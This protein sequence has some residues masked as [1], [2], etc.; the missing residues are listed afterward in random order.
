VVR[1]ARQAGWRSIPPPAPDA[2]IPRAIAISRAICR[3]GAQIGHVPR[4]PR[5]ASRSSRRG[6]RWPA[7]DRG[8]RLAGPAG[9][10]ANAVHAGRPRRDDRRPCRPTWRTGLQRAPSRRTCFQV[11]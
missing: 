3:D 8:E 6:S 7:S 11:R 9:L 5:R 1:C 4:P 10:A 2:F